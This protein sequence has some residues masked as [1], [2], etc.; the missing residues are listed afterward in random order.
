MSLQLQRDYP[1]LPQQ[2][3][4]CHAIEDPLPFG[5]LVGGAFL[6][7]AYKMLDVSMHVPPL[8]S[9]KEM[10]T[11]HIWAHFLNLRNIKY[12]ILFH[13]RKP[14]STFNIL[15][16]TLNHVVPTTSNCFIIQHYF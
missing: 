12:L 3:L 11:E 13:T 4:E 10:N 9:L 14:T 5:S 16:I 7:Q 8:Q 15:Y 6:A 1:L 2:Y